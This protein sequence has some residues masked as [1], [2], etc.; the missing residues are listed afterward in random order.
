MFTKA[1]EALQTYF[2]YSDFRKGQKEIVEKLL[3]GHDTIGILPTGGGK[4]ICYQV[5][6]LCLEGVTLVISPLISLMKDQVDALTHIGIS[7]TFLNSSVSSGEIE[8]RLINA[9]KG[10]YQL[11]YIA[12]E[13]LESPSFL[14]FLHKL[15]ISLVA[16]DEAHCVSQW[17]HDFRPHYR[18]IR[19]MLDELSPKPRIVA[20]TATATKEVLRDIQTHF[21]IDSSNIVVTG[22][23]RDNLSF[24]V[25]KGVKKRDFLLDY[26]SKNKNQS[27][28]VYAATKKEVDRIHSFLQKR[29]V[30]VAKYHAGMGKEEREREQERFLHDDVQ[31][32]VA[33]NAFGMGIDKSNVRYVLHNNMPKNMESYYQEAGRAG[34]D[35]EPSECVLLFSPQDIQ[36]QKFLLGQTNLTAD[37]KEKEYEKLKQMVDYCHTESCLQTYILHYFGDRTETSQC[38]RCSNC[39]DDR[40]KVDMTTEAQMILSCIK[41]MGEKFGKTLVAQVLKGSKSK[42]VLEL[43]FQEL[44]T[45]GL[46]KKLPEKDIVQLID[47][48]IAEG[49]A[50]LNGDQYPVVTLNEQSYRVLKG[51]QKVWKREAIKTKQIAVDDELFERLRTVRKELAAQEKVAPFVIFA[52]SALRDMCELLPTTIEQFLSVKGVGQKKAEVYGTSFLNVIRSYVEE[53]GIQPIKRVEKSTVK[54]DIPSHIQSYNRFQE[55]QSIEAIAKERGLSVVTIENHLFRCAQEGLNLDWSHFI[56]SKDHE[57]MILNKINEIGAEKLKPL[58]EELPEDITYREIKAVIMKH[59]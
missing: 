21:R 44:S 55:E 26:V 52:D 56:S 27:G 48:L 30:N 25:V 29:K 32:M 13:R 23:A 43:K 3:R 15:P 9:Q 11:I 36:T 58:K 2:G 49:Y 6:A 14:R 20:L 28:I 39:T 50:T 8:Q 7:A 5:P 24:H 54:D 4:S 38:G 47:F 42:R 31:V 59:F 41:R 10:D 34:R 57:E 40:P 16:I 18:M 35:G 1:I 53:K 46:L 51:E 12:P 45:Y 33:T 19:P 37:L 17:G 22:F